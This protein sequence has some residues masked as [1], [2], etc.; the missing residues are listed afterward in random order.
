MYKTCLQKPCKTHQVVGFMI[1]PG[2]YANPDSWSGLSLGWLQHFSQM[3][4]VGAKEFDFSQGYSLKGV[5]FNYKV[6]V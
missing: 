4:K 3:E 2:F 1:K 6:T 5:L